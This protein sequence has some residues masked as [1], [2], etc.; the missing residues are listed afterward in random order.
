MKHIGGEGD[1]E[2][3]ASADLC[4][5]TPMIDRRTK[6]MNAAIK[7]IARKGTRGLRIEDVARAARVS[8][9]LIYHHFG[10]RATLLQSALEYIGTR[11][12]EY[13]RPHQGTGRDMVLSALLDEIQDDDAVRTN[14]AAWSE[15]RDTAIFDHALRTTIAALTERWVDDIANLIHV[16]Q[17]DGSIDLK[18]DRQAAAIR[19]SAFVEGISAR[20]LTGQ[21][22]ATGARAHLAATTAS[23]L[24]ANPVHGP[25]GSA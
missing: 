23:V 1:A 17:Q 19:L 15:L 20:W 3:S 18:V 22:T 16:G 9:A 8:P 24:N 2:I 10:D 25:T 7:Q 21:V 12:N 6:L 11:A 5:N 14:S 13:T 4:Q